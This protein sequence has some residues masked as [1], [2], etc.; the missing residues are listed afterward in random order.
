MNG[1]VVSGKAK[2]APLVS[3]SSDAPA[4]ATLITKDLIPGTGATVAKGA[5]VTANYCGVGLTSRAIFDSSW[6]RGGQPIQFGLN[7]V[8]PGWTNGLPGMKVGGRRLLIIPGSLAYGDNPPPGSNIGVNEAL[9][10]V[11]D[12]TAVS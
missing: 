4:P 3:I 5:T 7:E 12:L 11:V 1:V 9:V 8:I 10:F 2:V 6:A